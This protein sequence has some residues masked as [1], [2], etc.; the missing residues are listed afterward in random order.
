MPNRDRYHQAVKNALLNDGWDIT[1]DPLHLRWGRKDLYV[2]L[3]A[4]QLLAVEKDGQRI[5]VEIKTF[6]GLSEVADLQ[7][8]MGQYCVYRSVMKRIDADRALYLAIHDEVFADV[9]DEPI[10]QVLLEDYQ[11]RLIV[12]DPRQE[13]I[14]KWIH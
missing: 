13:V 10:G 14:L 5:A 7:Q 1:A 6:G 11:L 12:F 9:F 4:E 3:A 8:A 2:D